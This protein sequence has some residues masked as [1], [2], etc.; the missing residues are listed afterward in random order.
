MLFIFP[1][2]LLRCPAWLYC[3]WGRPH[4]F[5]MEGVNQHIFWIFLLSHHPPIF[6]VGSAEPAQSFKLRN[7][8]EFCEREARDENGTKRVVRVFVWMR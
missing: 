1:S 7:K 2:S 4:P 6:T 3:R 5:Q 8:L